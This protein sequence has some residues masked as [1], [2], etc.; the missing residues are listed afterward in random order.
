VF[1]ILNS[2][3]VTFVSDLEL[4]RPPSIAVR[5]HS[6]DQ[7]VLARKVEARKC[8]TEIVGNIQ[9]ERLYRRVFFFSVVP[10]ARNNPQR[11]AKCVW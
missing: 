11:F 4:I 7:K 9:V 8:T 2:V 5:A 3:P 1:L 6:L 10:P